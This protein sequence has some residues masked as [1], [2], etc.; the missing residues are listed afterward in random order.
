MLSLSIGFLLIVQI[1]MLSKN[2]T[3][4]ETFIDGLYDL[5]PFDRGSFS[6]NM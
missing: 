5:K 1:Q 3:T 2:I 4:I 6:E